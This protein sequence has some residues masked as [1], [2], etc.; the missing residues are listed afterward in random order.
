MAMITQLN[1]NASSA[2]LSHT[3]KKKV[4]YHQVQLPWTPI[5][6][7]GGPESYH[8]SCVVLTAND[9]YPLTLPQLHL[10][11]QSKPFNISK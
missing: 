3:I 2:T 11:Q 9:F 1:T 8:L 10:T 5:H 6:N 7:I 4:V